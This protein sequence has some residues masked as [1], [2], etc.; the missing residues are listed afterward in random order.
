MENF[1]PKL[2]CEMFRRHHSRHGWFYCCRCFEYFDDGNDL[3]AHQDRGGCPFK[4]VTRGCDEYGTNPVIKCAH[5]NGQWDSQMS[6]WKELF[7]KYRGKE[8]PEDPRVSE[9]LSGYPIDQPQPTSP[10]PWDN[11]VHRSLLSPTSPLH[12][13]LAPDSSPITSHTNNGDTFA[14]TD[15]RARALRTLAEMLWHHVNT[16]TSLPD[17]WLRGTYERVMGSFRTPTQCPNPNLAVSLL[18]H[19]V[20]QLWQLAIGETQWTVALW[21]NLE[22][23]ARHWIRPENSRALEPPASD[24][25]HALAHDVRPFD[26]GVGDLSHQGG[27]TQA[28]TPANGETTALRRY[29][30][31]TDRRNIGSQQHPSHRIHQSVSLVTPF[32][33]TI[34]SLMPRTSHADDL[35]HRVNQH[36]FDVSS[37]SQSQAPLHSGSISSYEHVARPSID[38]R[39]LSYSTDPTSLMSQT[40]P[41]EGSQYIQKAVPT[42]QSEQSLLPGPSTGRDPTSPS[43]NDVTDFEDW[44]LDLN[45]FLGLL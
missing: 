27:G 19:F 42:E 36:A 40:A 32:D 33:R 5:A 26:G 35:H 16:P 18:E 44:T 39:N 15:D 17:V 43:N 28:T 11:A 3:K 21:T 14:P 2:T 25:D 6:Q 29:H 37:V 7:R 30:Q 10:R 23:F 22:T 9:D 8:P 13:P 34:D 41:Q 20:V 12:F 31:L 38:H 24:L 1:R 4:C 45:D